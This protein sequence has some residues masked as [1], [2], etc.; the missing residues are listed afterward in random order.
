MRCLGCSPAAPHS[1]LRHCAVLE[2]AEGFGARKPSLGV[3]TQADA[4]GTTNDNFTAILASLPHSL[5]QLK[6]DVEAL[7]VSGGPRV[8]LDLSPGS[9]EVKITAEAQGA[10]PCLEEDAPVAAD[11]A[12][13]AGKLSTKTQ[14]AT[15]TVSTS[16]P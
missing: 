11:A 15:W 10:P 3:K 16:A 5:A 14:R 8:H 7:L 2:Y 9:L 4:Q 13:P 12:T 6:A 1:K